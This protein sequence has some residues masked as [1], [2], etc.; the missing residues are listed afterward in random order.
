MSKEQTHELLKY[1]FLKREFITS[2]GDI[3]QSV[4]STTEL[5]TIEFS[6][7]KESIQ[8]WASEY[9][10]IIVPD[11]NEQIEIEIQHPIEGRNWTTLKMEKMKTLSEF[12]KDKSEWIA[13]FSPISYINVIDSCDRFLINVRPI[14][15]GRDRIAIPFTIKPDLV[16]FSID[17][18]GYNVELTFFKEKE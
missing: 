10:N 6:E 18:S 11:P 5:S 13:Y 4:G 1:K 12:I 14:N 16:I 9:L 15:L 7:Y 17:S 2:D 3:L 8:Q